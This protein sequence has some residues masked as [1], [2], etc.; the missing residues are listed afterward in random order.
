LRAA[1]STLFLTYPLMVSIQL[2]S[3][4]MGR[5]TGKGLASNLRQHYTA[6][7]LYLAVLL[8]VVA[9]TINIAADL[10]AM[11]AAAKLVLGGPQHVYVVALG[12]LSLVLQVFV[13]YERYAQI[14]KWLTLAL[15]AYVAVVFVVPIAW[16][17]V[18]KSVL[19]PRVS[20]SAGYLTTIVAVLG[21]T[22]SPYLFFW[23]ASQ[24]VEEIRLQPGQRALRFAPW[25]AAGQFERIHI[26]TWVG[27]A[28]SNAVAFFIMLTA[29]ATLHAH[30]IDVKTSADAALALKPIAG[31]FAFVLF[32]LGIVGTGL[33]ALPVLAGSAAYAA[34]GSFKWRNSLALQATLAKEFY[35]VIAVAILGG[36]IITFINFDPIKALYWSAVI[37]G[38]AAVPIMILVMVMASSRRVMGEFA[39]SGLL[40]WG[41]LDGDGDHG[42]G[43]RRNV[44]ASVSGSLDL[45]RSALA[46]KCPPRISCSLTRSLDRKR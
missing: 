6:W 18:L 20:L 41:R 21:T 15:L 34:A 43:G 4:R 31:K 38:V 17:D 37:N 29:A 12:V 14:L 39:V 32:S 25:Q 1:L 45:K 44:V 42:S 11:G 3:A 13:T 16:T 10:A 30:H 28:V 24:E 2:V 8:L 46:W 26:D 40:R 19:M 36:V 22:I 33:L 7:I 27:M 35:A 23:Q 9:N 5:V